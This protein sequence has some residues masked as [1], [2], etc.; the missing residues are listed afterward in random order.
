MRIALIQKPALQTKK[1]R[2]AGNN[3]TA[4]TH[5]PVVQHQALSGRGGPLGGVEGEGGALGVH[6]D[7]AAIVV[8][9]AVA[10]FGAE[11]RYS[12]ACGR[13]ARY[14]VHIHYGNFAA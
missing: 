5:P 3:P 4:Q 10:G 14:P 1:L 8:L 2:R 9:L 12:V 7:D 11:L 6:A 13:I